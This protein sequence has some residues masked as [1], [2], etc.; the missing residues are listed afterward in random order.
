MAKKEKYTVIKNSI[1]ELEKFIIENSKKQLSEVIIEGNYNEITRFIFD[2]VI[3]FSKDSI[4]N[5]TSGHDLTDFVLWSN[6][7]TF[8][9]VFITNLEEF[10][11]HRG[12]QKNEKGIPKFSDF[13]I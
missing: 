7:F 6:E 8:L 2:F 12:F 9:E 11:K 1:K 13:Q 5:H 3:S 10:F 4:N